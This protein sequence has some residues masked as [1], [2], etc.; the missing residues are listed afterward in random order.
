VGSTQEEER[1]EHED[2]EEAGRKNSGTRID[3]KNDATILDGF[4]G[5]R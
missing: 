1:E 3:D 2:A 5:R 4:E